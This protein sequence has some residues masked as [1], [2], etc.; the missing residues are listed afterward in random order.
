MF[1]LVVT[2]CISNLYQI[3]LQKAENT[4]KSSPPYLLF[5]ECLRAVSNSRPPIETIYWHWAP[6]NLVIFLYIETNCLDCLCYQMF[7]VH[8]ACSIENQVWTLSKQ[9]WDRVLPTGFLP[10]TLL[11]NSHM[12]AKNWGKFWWIFDDGVKIVQPAEVGLL[13]A[14]LLLLLLMLLLV[15]W[16]KAAGQLF[17]RFIPVC[18]ASKTPLTLFYLKHLPCFNPFVT[19]E[20]T[21]QEW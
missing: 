6:P 15:R 14:R 20:L 3:D 5:L 2:S 12:S 16:R 7:K 21:Q 19:R 10:P 13:M 4:S 11:H 1:S 17:R 8:R 9:V 18:L